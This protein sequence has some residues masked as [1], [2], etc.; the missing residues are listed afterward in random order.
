LTSA[1]STQAKKLA[2]GKTGIFE[3]CKPWKA[4]IFFVRTFPPWQEEHIKLT[5]E[6]IELFGPLDIKTISTKIEKTSLKRAMPVI[7]GLKKPFDAGESKEVLTQI[8]LAFD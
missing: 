1:A 7:H 8:S 3:P 2:K 4:T 6:V 5:R